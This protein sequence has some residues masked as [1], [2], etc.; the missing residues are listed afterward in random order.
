MSKN[1]NYLLRFI[2]IVL[3]LTEVLYIPRL[4]KIK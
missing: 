4:Y 3:I 2:L 1:L